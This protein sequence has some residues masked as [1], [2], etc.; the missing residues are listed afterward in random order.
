MLNYQHE[1]LEE[2]PADVKRTPSANRKGA[3]FSATWTETLKL[4]ERELLQLEAH[5]DRTR[6]KTF[7]RGTVVRRDGQLRSDAPQPENPGVILTFDVFKPN[8]QR[9]ASGQRL[10]KYVPVQF[11]C[12]TF[13]HWKDNVRAIALAL[14]ALRKIER[15]G[16]ARATVAEVGR[17]ALPPAFEGRG[18]TVDDAWQVLAR[19]SS[20][21]VEQLMGVGARIKDAYREAA[22]RTHPDRGGNHDDAAKVNVAY[23]VLKAHLGMDGGRE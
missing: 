13:T 16:V 10:G 3:L 6:I 21:T 11:E 17:K 9:N 18:M 23:E 12:D 1:P 20:F 22:M 14:E 8:G 4:L 15:Y 5:P 2:W 7:H 19:F